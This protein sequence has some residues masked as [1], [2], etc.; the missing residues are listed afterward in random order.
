MTLL[1]ERLQ[2]AKDALQTARQGGGPTSA[3]RLREAKEQAEHFHAMLL[4]AEGTQH[5]VAI[6]LTRSRDEVKLLEQK[7][8]GYDSV[9]H[10]LDQVLTLRAHIQD[11]EGRLDRSQDKVSSYQVCEVLNYNIQIFN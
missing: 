3:L 6:E 11:L 9:A 1:S 4:E 10:Q 5:R 8:A 2:K 7:L